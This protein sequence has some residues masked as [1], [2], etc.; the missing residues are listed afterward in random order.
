MAREKG[1]LLFPLTFNDG[2]VIPPEVLSEFKEQLFVIAGGHSIAGTV[3]GEYRMKSGSKQVEELLEI[4]VAVEEQ[5]VPELR[6]LVAVYGQRL[7]QES[8]Y[9]ERTKSV[10]EFVQPLG[11]EGAQS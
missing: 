11:P 4:W 7:G 3:K 2:T 9:F 1:V 10:V 5:D 8:M 6:R